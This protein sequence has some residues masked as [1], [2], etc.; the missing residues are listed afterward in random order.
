MTGEERIAIGADIHA[1]LAA[2]RATLSDAAKQ[3][4]TRIVVAGDIVGFGP[5]PNEVVD[6]LRAA[7]AELVR[8]NHEQDY[9]AGYARPEICEHWQSD[10]QLAAMCWYLDRLG[11]D[12]S[13]FLAALPE[14]LW[15]DEATLVTHG[16]PRHI[17]DGIRTDTPEAAVAAMF[18]GVAARLAF[19]GHTH[20]AMRRTFADRVVVNGGS[21]GSPL[22]GDPRAAYVIAT[23]ARDAAPGSWEVIQRRVPYDLTATLSAYNAG[24]RQADP[25]FVAIMERQLHTGRPYLGPWLRASAG[26]TVAQRPAALTSFLLAHP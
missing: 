7:R 15:L 11:E 2:L 25:A 12:R 17:R 23:R 1:N 16:S 9:V 5:Q 26:L 21:V 14:R 10:P 3:G 24:M 20:R 19:V 22:D 4:A 18:V 13:T 8:G 6:L